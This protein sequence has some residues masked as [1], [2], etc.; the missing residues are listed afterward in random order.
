[1]KLVGVT[2]IAAK[3][4]LD[5]LDRVCIEQVSQL[6]LAEEL[7]DLLDADAVEEVE[8]Q[9]RGNPSNADQA[10]FAC[11]ETCAREIRRGFAQTLLRERR[12][13]LRVRRRGPP[14][15][16]RGCRPLPA[17]P[18]VSCL[19]GPP[20]APRGRRRVLRY[21]RGH[22][23]LTTAQANGGDGSPHPHEQKLHEVVNSLTAES[24]KSF[25]AARIAGTSRSPP[26]A[27]PAPPPRV[28]LNRSLRVML[29]VG[30]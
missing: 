19:P 20:E 7:R 12:A 13:L 5:L 25:V 24:F 14:D 6:F 2:G 21:A 28:N 1:M 16:R 30:T 27:S 10:G 8:R 18:S 22:R 26:S 29:G 3:L 4:S 9:L 17:T 15:R 11:A 23:P